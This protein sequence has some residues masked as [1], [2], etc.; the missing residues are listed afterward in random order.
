MEIV[1]A[2]QNDRVTVS[3]PGLPGYTAEHDVPPQQFEFDYTNRAELPAAIDGQDDKG[4][5]K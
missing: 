4:V 2:F 3:N 5:L 1:S